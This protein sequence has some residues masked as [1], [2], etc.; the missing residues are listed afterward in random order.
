MTEKMRSQVQVAK[1]SSL[2]RVAGFW[3]RSSDIHKRLKVKLLLLHIEQNQLSG[4]GQLVRMPPGHIP[5]EVFQTCPSARIPR[6]RPRTGKTK[7]TNKTCTAAY[8]VYVV[9]FIEVESPLHTDALTAPQLP[10]H[11]LPSMAWHCSD[12]RERE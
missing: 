7:I 2:H 10:E 8:R 6:G 11:Q 4:F 1:M 9:A 5:R 3:I 12:H